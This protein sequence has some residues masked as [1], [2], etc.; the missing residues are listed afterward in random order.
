M[1]EWRA[2]RLVL[3]RAPGPVSRNEVQR[4]GDRSWDFLARVQLL[5][6]Y[7]FVAES[8]GCPKPGHRMSGA[9]AVRGR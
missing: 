4:L 9:F 8:C 5:P 7:S 1:N 6:G 2:E 3:A